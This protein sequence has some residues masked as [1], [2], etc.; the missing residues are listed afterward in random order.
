MREEE[1]RSSS[2]ITATTGKLTFETVS[3]ASLSLR[4][5]YFRAS[6]QRGPRLEDGVGQREQRSSRA[7]EIS[8]DSFI[9]IPFGAHLLSPHFS[10]PRGFWFPL[11]SDP[12]GHTDQTL[13]R[14]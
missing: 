10:H 4:S 9:I 13:V 5:C 12:L 3:P 1:A 11:L 7:K 2:V 8:I 14:V 6:V